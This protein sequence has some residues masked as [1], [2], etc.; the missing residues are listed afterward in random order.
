[1]GLDRT[2][3]LGVEGTQLVISLRFFILVLTNYAS[4]GALGV[5]DK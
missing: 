2:R 1:M 3:G 4:N 5:S